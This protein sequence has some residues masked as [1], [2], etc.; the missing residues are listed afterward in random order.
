MADSSDSVSVDMESIPLAGKEHVVKTAHGSVSVAV[1]GD[2]DKPALI[3]YPDLALNHISCFQGLLFCPEAFSLLV[4]NFCIYHISPPGHELGA[5]VAA[6]D[7][8]SLCVDDLA[9]QVSEILDYFG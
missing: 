8:L 1:F 2:Q 6:S 7:E 3:T 5:A 9:D 4:H